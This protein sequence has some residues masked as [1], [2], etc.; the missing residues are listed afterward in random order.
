MSRLC[1]W[2]SGSYEDSVHQIDG[3]NVAVKFSGQ[4][5]GKDDN[6]IKHATHVMIKEKRSWKQLGRILSVA[7]V[8]RENN[9][10][11][12]VLIVRLMADQPMF[13]S[14]NKL[15]E[16]YGWNNCDNHLSGITHH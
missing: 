10:R 7:E 16:H 9:I 8:E 1:L 11:K 12:F 4:N 13:N 6:F 2:M 15:C 3:E 14:K 5:S